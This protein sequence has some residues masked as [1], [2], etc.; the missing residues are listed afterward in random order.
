MTPF[1]SACTAFFAGWGKRVGDREVARLTRADHRTLL[2]W[3]IEVW[4]ANYELCREWDAYSEDESGDPPETDPREFDYRAPLHDAGLYS[5]AP[6]DAFLDARKRVGAWIWSRLGDP[7]IE[8]WAGAHPH[9]HTVGRVG[10]EVEG[11]AWLLGYGSARLDGVRFWLGLDPSDVAQDIAL[12]DLSRQLQEWERGRI[13]A[14]S[15]EGLAEA[16]RGLGRLLSAAPTMPTKAQL[17]DFLLANVRRSGTVDLDDPRQFLRLHQSFFE[18]DECLRD[19]LRE[20]LL[21]D[22]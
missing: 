16:T 5:V 9:G 20:E 13:V 22:W 7:K 12:L 10:L 8:G 2:D 19:E 3:I 14:M 18:P 4:F 21:D 17:F 15:S 1:P 6:L 11:G